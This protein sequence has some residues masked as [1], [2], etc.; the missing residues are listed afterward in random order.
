MKTNNDNDL[1][2]FYNENYPTPTLMYFSFGILCLI[3]SA[4]NLIPIKNIDNTPI[5]NWCAVIICSFFAV[6]SF[7]KSWNSFDFNRLAEKFFNE[8]G[9]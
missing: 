1:R 8:K 3:V 9:R 5:L 4:V 2:K 7:K 6:D